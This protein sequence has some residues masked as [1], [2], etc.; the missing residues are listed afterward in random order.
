[1]MDISVNKDN[2]RSKCQ[3]CSINNSDKEI[4]FGRYSNI[5]LRLC[6]DCSVKLC[7]LLN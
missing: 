3:A 6:T 4:K 7:E 1:M 5:T 2:T